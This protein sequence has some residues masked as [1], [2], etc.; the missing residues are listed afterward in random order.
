MSKNRDNDMQVTFSGAA[1]RANT[2]AVEVLTVSLDSL[3]KLVHLLALHHEDDDAYAGTYI[4][5]EIRRRYS[6]VCR[7]P[8]PG[9]YT[10]P[11]A[12]GPMTLQEH[13]PNS[14]PEILGHLN[15][16]LRAVHSQNESEL[17]RMLPAPRIRA[18]ATRALHNMVPD[19]RSGAR[20]RVD[21]PSGREIFTP[22]RTTRRF[23]KSFSASG[24]QHDIENSVAGDLKE[25][26]FQQQRI[27]LQH[28]PTGRQLTCPYPREL[29]STLI[30]CRR[31]LVQVIGEVATGPGDVPKRIRSVDTICPVDFSPIELT[32]FTTGGCW[33]RAKQ[34]LTFEPAMDDAYQHFVLREAPCYGHA[35]SPLQGGLS[36]PS[37]LRTYARRLPGTRW[38]APPLT[39]DL[40]TATH[41]I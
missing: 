12:L 30:D 21:T 36:P 1:T 41:R 16:V 15:G 5:A 14:A 6:I 19:P 10:I 13:S 7:L 40:I 25:I 2:V 39:E 27:C 24:E 22:N 32:G 17:E 23:L 20:I 28:P 26:D 8:K 35:M 31:T 29:E 9:S 34:P 38:T 18:A 37:R 4:P 11:L 3:Q 33:V